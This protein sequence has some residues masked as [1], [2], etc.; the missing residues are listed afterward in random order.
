MPSRLVRSIRANVLIGLF[1]T[2][3]IAGTLLV[4]NFIVKLLT[5]LVMPSVWLASRYGFL[6]RLAALGLVLVLL[7]LVGLLARNVV[8]RGLYR[9]GDRLL[10]RIPVI[11]GIYTTIR[12]I[13][14]SLISSRT[15]TMFKAVVAVPFPGPGMWS[16]GFVTSH[17]A[18]LAD[19]ASTPDLVTVFVPTAPNPTTGFLLLVP[20]ATLRP[21]TLSVTDAMKMVMSAGAVTPGVPG[22]RR[23]SLLEQLE[24]WLRGGEPGPDLPPAPPAAPSDAA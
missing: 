17:G 5:N 23:S 8:G 21:V 14:E 15:N 9:L 7:Y 11:S 1:L 22:T 19:T 16:I 4:V 24:S 20:R 13:G 6:Y 2:G 3:P 12:Q 18:P 10:G